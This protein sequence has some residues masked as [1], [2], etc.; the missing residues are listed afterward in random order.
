MSA[1]AQALP[2]SSLSI[3]RLSS[4][5]QRRLEQP[6][7]AAGRV[8]SVF[9][10]SINLQ[11]RDERL[12]VL[13]GPG[14]LLAPFAASLSVLPRWDSIEPG[15]PVWTHGG[16]VRVG[17]LAI[18]SGTGTVVD[19]S[20]PPA[21]E[22]PRALGGSLCHLPDESPAPAL[23]S[24]T[25]RMARERLATGIRDRDPGALVEGARALIGLGEGLTPAGDDCLVGA[26]GAVWRF[27]PGWIGQHR[28]VRHDLARAATRGTTTVAREFILHA[29]EGRFSELLVDLL[30]ARS[31]GDVA[32]A[33][34]LV[35]GTGATS[36]AD[37]LT[38][39]RL[40]LRALS[41]PG[42]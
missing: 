1:M 14:P 36:G 29:L 41:A 5:V 22:G 35:R 26:L 32:R 28:V 27:A 40:A 10:R 8:H 3:V 17:P 24:A 4:A 21:D 7:V 31:S 6:S 15:A 33:A 38:G 39:L 37:T 13:H 23:D 25:G 30:T 9:E 12:L 16:R 42:S 18:D 19:L 2:V 34:A 11:W 20:V